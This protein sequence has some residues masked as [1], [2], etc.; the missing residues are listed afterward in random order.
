MVQDERRRRFIGRA[1]AASAAGLPLLQ[2]QA[3]WALPKTLPGT[4]RFAVSDSW[5]P[6]Y[7]VRTQGEPVS[8]LMLDL[9]HL[10]AQAAPARAVLVKLPSQRIDAAIHDG[11]VDLH[12]LI[13]PTWY[14]P[15]GPPGRL[16]PA[17]LVLEDVLVTREPGPPLELPAQRGLR[18]G[19]VLGYRYD[20]LQSGFDVGALRREDAPSPWHML[21]KLRLGR[22]E[23]AVCDRRVLAH[24]NEARPEAERLHVRQRVARMPTY[25]CVSPRSAWPQDLLL[26]VLQRVVKQPPMKRLLAG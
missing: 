24:Y 18:V 11:E 9:I 20:S 21:E 23:A 2:P 25:A 8:G 4:L 12:C 3:T 14:G 22:T 6:P 17:L 7:I 19:T 10:V 15:E 5:V 26:Q 1:L 16:G 13:S